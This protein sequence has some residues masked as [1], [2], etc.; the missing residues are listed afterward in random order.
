MKNLQTV[1]VYGIPYLTACAALYHIAYWG[2]FNVNG[3]AYIGLSDLIKSFVQPCLYFFVLVFFSFILNEGILKIGL[4]FPYG[5]GRNTPTGKALN[6]GW[7]KSI[8]TL[9][10]LVGI[11][12]FYSNGDTFRWLYWAFIVA[13]VPIFVIDDLGLWVDEFI[14]SKWRVHAIR[15]IVFLP[16]LSFASGKYQSELIYKNIHYQYTTTV[17]LNQDSNSNKSDTL[18]FL[19][20]LG[21]YFFLTDLKNT[22]IIFLSND[23]LPVL[24]FTNK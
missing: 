11:I 18:K 13:T 3:L 4:I 7:V 22:K 10:W 16:I 8:L 1:T 15:I 12:F 19:G 14:D 9:L 21:N 23:E 5:G 24:E 6:S 20:Y 17:V 2:T